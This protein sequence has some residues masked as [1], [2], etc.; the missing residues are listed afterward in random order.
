MAAAITGFILILFVILQLGQGVL[1]DIYLEI[2][3]PPPVASV[4]QYYWIAADGILLISTLIYY[5][6]LR[7]TAGQSALRNEFC[8]VPAL[9]M[10]WAVYL[11]VVLLPRSIW[12]MTASGRCLGKVE[13]NNATSEIANF[14]NKIGVSAL[15]SSLDENFWVT[16]VSA[17]TTSL[18]VLLTMAQQSEHGLL[19]RGVALDFDIAEATFGTIDAVEYWQPFF[20]AQN[21]N[22]CSIVPPQVCNSTS[23]FLM[24]NETFQCGTSTSSEAKS[25]ELIE[26]LDGPVGYMLIVVA[27][28]S[29]TLPFF[30]IWQLQKRS[31]LLRQSLDGGADEVETDRVFAALEVVYMLF[32]LFFINIPGFAL[33]MY[34]WLVLKQTI[35]ALITK[36]L[37][38]IIF[39]LLL[40]YVKY[41]QPRLRKY[42]KK[43]DKRVHPAQHARPRKINGEDTV[44]G[45]QRR[46]WIKPTTVAKAADSFVAHGN[47]KV[48]PERGGSGEG[49]RTPRSS[50]H[51]RG[52]LS[53]QDDIWHSSNN[54]ASGPNYLAPS[55][56]TPIPP[57]DADNIPLCNDVDDVPVTI[58]PADTESTN[59][60]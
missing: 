49:R 14:G 19:R 40:I 52:K 55:I 15:T 31:I 29:F 30:A 11:V 21:V 42:L 34:I 1:L 51:S 22:C 35:T 7:G 44:Q 18:L 6:A 45:P 57:S 10:A 58:L 4:S 36:N 24:G 41:I 48:Y 20:D 12:V 25:A 23:S 56:P 17:G 26:A 16:I 33:R 8:G 3:V 2:Y 27:S 32:D 39:R 47:Q 38:G 50:M 5:I 13:V 37:M 59:S 54:D 46:N 53:R 43:G 9:A 60:L 28:T